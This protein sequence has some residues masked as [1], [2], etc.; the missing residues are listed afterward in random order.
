MRHK[1]CS[2]SNIAHLTLHWYAGSFVWRPGMHAIEWCPDG[3]NEA[4]WDLI[5][6]RPDSRDTF[7][8]TYAD[9]VRTCT[10]YAR[11][12]RMPQAYP[13]HREPS[14]PDFP[15]ASEHNAL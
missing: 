14:F 11:S 10:Y 6:F 1:P 9:F 8:E 7:H 4:P 13:G 5:P 12:K 2:D 15:A 3:Y